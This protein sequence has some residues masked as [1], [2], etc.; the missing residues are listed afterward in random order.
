MELSWA[1][2]R[3]RKNSRL[4]TTDARC[5]S[6][7]V[8]DTSTIGSSVRIQ[9][10]IEIRSVGNGVVL[11]GGTEGVGGVAAGGGRRLDGGVD[12]QKHSAVSGTGK[13]SE[14]LEL[15][16]DSR[17][18][19]WHQL[20]EASTP[21]RL[22]TSLGASSSEASI[23]ASVGNDASLVSNGANGVDGSEGGLALGL[24]TI[25]EDG[26]DNG[27]GEV[28]GAAGDQ[29]QGHCHL[30]LDGEGT[31]GGNKGLELRVGKDQGAGP[32]IETIGINGVG[33]D[34]GR[35]DDTKVGTSTTEGIPEFL[36][37]SGDG[38][39]L[40]SRGNDVESLEV[41]DTQAVETH[42][43]SNTSTEN[44]TKSADTIAGTSGNQGAG[45]S[46]GSSNLGNLGT[47]LN[48][49]SISIGGEGDGVETSEV[50]EETI[51]LKGEGVGPAVATVLGQE[52]NLLLK[53][54]S[55]LYSN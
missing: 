22:E 35:G 42:Q 10:R 7:Q 54:E 31:H 33:D 3:E 4:V 30:G 39:G 12:V 45:S 38:N 19:L 21:G 15:G 9:A 23:P 53:T 27:R 26:E 50:D 41:I 8:T 44:G 36:V 51:L 13:S 16:V 34:D 48:D 32:G 49:G 29:G 14:G 25:V 18:G 5:R 40:S 17:P 24:G 43:V 20:H 46:S 37:L 11:D 55:D 28:R 1:N 2:I 52:R 47:S 6:P